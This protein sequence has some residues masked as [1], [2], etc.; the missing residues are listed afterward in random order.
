MISQT[1][2][3]HLQS[4]RESSPELKEIPLTVLPVPPVRRLI[5]AFAR[6]FNA[7]ERHREVVL[8]L[9]NFEVNVSDRSEQATPALCRNSKGNFMLSRHTYDNIIQYVTLYP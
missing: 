2:E 7:N 9:L 3:K 5:S 1:Q 4:F 8:V 6:P